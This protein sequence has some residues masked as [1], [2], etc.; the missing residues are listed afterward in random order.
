MDGQ[1]QLTQIFGSDLK[2]EPGTPD[3]VN[4]NVVI[5]NTGQYTYMLMIGLLSSSLL[6]DR[7]TLLQSVDQVRQNRRVDFG[8]LHFLMLFYRFF[9]FIDD[10]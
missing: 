6:P 8:I 9:E 7:R 1:I 10:L 5:L 2:G 4:Q 3:G